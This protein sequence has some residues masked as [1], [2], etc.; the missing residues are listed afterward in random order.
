MCVI[1]DTQC[2][3]RECGDSG[4]GH[5]RVWFGRSVRVVDI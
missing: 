1:N 4:R 2:V 3:M 5:L